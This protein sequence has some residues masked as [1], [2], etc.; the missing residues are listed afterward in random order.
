MVTWLYGDKQDELPLVLVTAAVS[1]TCKSSAA[2]TLSK[3]YWHYSLWLQ[4]NSG[5]CSWYFL[6]YNCCRSHYHFNRLFSPSTK[7]EWVLQYLSLKYMHGCILWKFCSQD[8]VKMHH[9]LYLIY[10]YPLMCLNI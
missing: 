3:W 1:N 8:I 7:T 2:G 10:C 6:F 9:I 5:C 4:Y